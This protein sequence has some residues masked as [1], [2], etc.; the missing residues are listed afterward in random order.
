M[1]SEFNVNEVDLELLVRLDADQERRTATSGYDFIGIVLR[2]EDKGEG[3]LELLENGFDKFGERDALVRLR[4]I[5]IFGKDGNGL[6]VRLALKL[7]ATV[8]ENEAEGG[9]IG[10]DTVVHDDEIVVGIGAQRVAVDDRGRAVGGP[11]RV[12]N[13]DLRIEN[14]GSVYARGGDTLAK[15]GNLADFFEK[16]HLA[17]SIAV[18]TD[19]GRVITTILLAGE[20]VTEDITNFLAILW[21]REHSQ[22]LLVG[23]DKGRWGRWEYVSRSRAVTI[24]TRTTDGEKE[25][26]IDTLGLR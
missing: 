11:S 13:R 21:E 22:L 10:D 15:A 4:V 8:L 24:P 17:G 18:D 7:V 14:L 25:K 6:R 2:L 3:S 9:G 12:C 1:A 23:D 20:T 26:W 16:K 5:D 19:A